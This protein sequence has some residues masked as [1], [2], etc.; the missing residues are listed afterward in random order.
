MVKFAGGQVTVDLDGDG[1]RVRVTD[2]EGQLQSESWCPSEFGTFDQLHSF[3]ADFKA[4]LISG[5]SRRVAELV[6]Y[7]LRVNDVHRMTIKNKAQLLRRYAQ[8][9]TAP[10]LSD[11]RTAEPA[12]IF[13]RHGAAMIGS[14][15]VW[16]SGNN[17]RV[18]V[19]VVNTGR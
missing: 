19:E 12:A 7:P 2:A 17:G 11:I 1:E 15:A 3:F 18:A 9:F 13:C 6:R 8:V 5:D 10:V 14:G 4:A 16:V